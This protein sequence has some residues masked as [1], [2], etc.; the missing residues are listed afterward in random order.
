MLEALDIALGRAPGI[1]QKCK[2]NRDEVGNGIYY[3]KILSTRQS[4]QGGVKSGKCDNR[5][6]SSTGSP[7]R[8]VMARTNVDRMVPEGAEETRN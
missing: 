2:T 7:G 3:K 6:D 5:W 1:G 4:F 8:E